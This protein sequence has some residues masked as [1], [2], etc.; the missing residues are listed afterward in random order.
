MMQHGPGYRGRTKPHVQRT[1]LPSVSLLPPSQ[2]L[3]THH[4]R[5]WRFLLLSVLSSSS[6]V[7]R[8]VIVGDEWSIGGERHGRLVQRMFM[9]R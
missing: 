8:Q 9:Q 1:T 6:V 5:F 2:L 3:L 4:V 7:I